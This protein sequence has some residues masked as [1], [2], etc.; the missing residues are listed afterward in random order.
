[1]ASYFRTTHFPL[2]WLLH[3]IGISLIHILLFDGPIPTA[4]LDLSSRHSPHQHCEYYPRP[5]NHHG[6]GRSLL[7]GILALV[8]E[9]SLALQHEVT[10]GFICDDL[11]L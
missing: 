7:S 2:L 4:A 3:L 5:V 9:R 8:T 11:A 1:M 10:F 6:P